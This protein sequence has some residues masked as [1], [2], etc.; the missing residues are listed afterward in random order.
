MANDP[1]IE[2]AQ[3]AAATPA[4][5][6]PPP[7]RDTYA[8]RLSALNDVNNANGIYSKDEV[9]RQAA[10]AELRSVIAA[11]ETEDEK[12]ARADMT[13]SERREQYGVGDPQLPRPWLENYNENFASWETPFYDMA[14]EHGL[15]ANQ[16]RGLRDAAVELGQVVSDT[17][18]PASESDLVRVLDKY[19]VG[20]RSRPA[21]VKLWRQI[22]GGAS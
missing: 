14:H 12:T 22:E 16:V 18:R 13:V 20:A 5:G 7:E 19:G 4:N 1:I 2:N 21:L 15:A 11:S 6:A 3:H 8:T 9:K 17:G 10:L